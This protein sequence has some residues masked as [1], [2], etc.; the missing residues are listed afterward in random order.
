MKKLYVIEALRK[1]HT[2]AEGGRHPSRLHLPRLNPKFDRW[3]KHEYDGTLFIS[4]LQTLSEKQVITNTMT[5]IIVDKLKEKE[6]PHSKAK[7]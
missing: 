2:S 4:L 3:R 1:A 5:E 6:E 7:L